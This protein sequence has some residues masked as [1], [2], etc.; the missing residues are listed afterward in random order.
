MQKNVLFS[1]TIKENLRWGNPNATDEEL[2][3]ACRLACADEFIQKMEGGY[4]APIAS[5]G[6][7]VSGGQRQRLCIARAA[8]IE[9]E[10]FV[11]DDSFSALDF[12]TDRTVRENL[13]KMY[14]DATKVIVAQRVG[15]IMD[16]DLILVLDAGKVV[17]KGTHRELLENCPTYRDIALSQLSK[18]ELGL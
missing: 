13:K 9:P 14:P 3:H 11:F 4:D 2:V 12:K 1:G 16:A 15:T 5:G 17:G 8:A 7:N 18:E 6:T 10:I